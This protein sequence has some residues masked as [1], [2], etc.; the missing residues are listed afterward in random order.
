MDKRQWLRE[1]GFDVGNRGRFSAEMLKALEE[2]EDGGS[3]AAPSVISDTEIL[4]FIR[5]QECDKYMTCVKGV[6]YCE[7]DEG[8]VP[9]YAAGAAMMV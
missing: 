5:C 2:Y 6:L 4:R 9:I 8:H 3:D 7:C 1:R